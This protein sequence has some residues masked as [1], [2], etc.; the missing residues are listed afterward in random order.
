M[1]KTTQSKSG[2]TGVLGV[3]SLVAW[4]P[5]PRDESRFA[6]ATIGAIGEDGRVYGLTIERMYGNWPEGV[7]YRAG[8]YVN[9][10]WSYGEIA[11]ASARDHAGRVASERRDEVRRSQPEARVPEVRR[12]SSSLPSPTYGGLTRPE[13]HSRW[14]ENG[15]RLERGEGLRYALTAEQIV[16]AK[17]HH[18]LGADSWA[19]DLWSLVEQSE[20]EQ[21][22]RGVSVVAPDDDLDVANASFEEICA[23]NLRDPVEGAR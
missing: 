15:L 1:T 18:A 20:L 22:R 4:T 17:A 9:P 21:A 12:P 8:A 5:D 23:F 16:V 10:S 6:L 7:K 19:R 2:R 14:R 13:C 11:L 3:G